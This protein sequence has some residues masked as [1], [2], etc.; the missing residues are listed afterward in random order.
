[1]NGQAI[2]FTAILFVAL[3]VAPTF[4]G[5]I[6]GIAFDLEQYFSLINGGFELFVVIYFFSDLVFHLVFRRPSP[7]IKYYMTLA[8]ETSSISWQYLITSL[9]GIVPFLLSMPVVVIVVKAFQLGGMKMALI[10]TCL[11]LSS[12]YL[13]LF[14][15]YS[16]KGSRLIFLIVLATN[17]G[18]ILQ[19]YLISFT[20]TVLVSWFAFA[21]LGLSLY[22]AYTQINR[23]LKMRLLYDRPRR[24]SWRRG[25]PK[26]QFKN[27]YYQLEWSLVVRNKRT[28]TNL[29]F[30]LVSMLIFPLLL[31]DKSPEALVNVMFF[32][33]T[34]FFVLQHGIYSLG[35]EGTF[36]DFLVTNISP[37]V[38]FT[39][40][41]AFY[42]YTCVL[43]FV[44]FLIPGII[45]ET[46]LVNL[47]CM[48]IYNI[49]VTIPL[50]LYR[51]VFNSTKIRLSENSMTNYEGMVT[52]PIILT[53]MVV[54]IAPFLVYGVGRV[55]FEQQAL[56]ML[57]IAGLIGIVTHRILIKTIAKLLVKK[58][59]ELSQGFK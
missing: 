31:S 8:S 54:M 58:K 35:W 10:T 25:L 48:L 50:V 37:K 53:S 3:K 1:M 42:S 24:S 40:R 34:C 18:L 55:L 30:G 28:R 43:G 4:Y 39:N 26:I 19:G 6:D 27:P 46:N 11:F 12:H 59:Y 20:P 52:S 23:K 56:Y 5:S 9:F 51:S 47:S 21:L 22:L 45:R 29:I 15:Q 13:G 33:G 36:F 41:Y 7:R 14:F 16:K 32:L 49:G 38:F 57:G 2:A 44:L 17:V